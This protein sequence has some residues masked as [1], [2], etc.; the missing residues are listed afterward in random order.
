MRKEDTRSDRNSKKKGKEKKHHLPNSTRKPSLTQ[1]K[2]AKL[3]HDRHTHEFCGKVKIH[4]RSLREDPSSNQRLRSSFGREDC[5]SAKDSTDKLSE[6][7]GQLEGKYFDYNGVSP[8]CPNNPEEKVFPLLHL[9]DR[10]LWFATLGGSPS[11][12][13]ANYRQRSG[14]RHQLAPECRK[15]SQ[16]LRFHRRQQRDDPNSAR[17]LDNN[18]A[19]DR[20]CDST[21]T[22]RLRLRQLRR[23]DHVAPYKS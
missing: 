2:E 10:R 1:I 8:D 17:G 20:G 3:R 5:E 6:L 4:E 9:Q 21:T 19:S 16:D 22:T 12:A 18:F 7:H 14:A 13:H 11:R 23:A 15:S